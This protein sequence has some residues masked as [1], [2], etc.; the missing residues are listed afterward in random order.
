MSRNI[1]KEANRLVKWCGCRDP[2]YL[3]G[4]LN[5][6]V[7]FRP[8]NGLKGLYVYSYRS[9]YIYINSELNEHM[10]KLVCTHEIAHDRFHRK[11]ARLKLSSQEII[12]YD[13]ISKSEWEADIFAAEFLL[14][15]EQVLRSMNDGEMDLVGVANKLLVPPK[16]LDYKFQI[17]KYKGY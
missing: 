3:A 5:I 15:D 11:L 7:R 8:M 12:S 16:I 13:A 2:F 10:Q 4:Q 9:R 14:D 1:L 17:L 6:E